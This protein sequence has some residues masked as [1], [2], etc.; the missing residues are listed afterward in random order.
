MP[1]TGFG[2]RNSAHSLRLEQVQAQAMGRIYSVFVT[3]E[4]KKSLSGYLPSAINFPDIRQ[5]FYEGG[6]L[7]MRLL[8]SSLRNIAPRC[9]SCGYGVAEEPW[10][11]REIKDPLFCCV[12]ERENIEC[13]NIKFFC[14][15]P[16]IIFL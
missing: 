7:V 12:A 11:R 3:V 2:Y 9:S 4:A 1:K 6:P 10:R 5:L 16:P 8:L 14:S 13:H 15:T